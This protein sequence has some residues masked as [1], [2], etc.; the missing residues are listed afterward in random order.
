MTSDYGKGTMKFKY[1]NNLVTFVAG[2]SDQI[3]EVG[4]K[5]LERMWRKE[6]KVMP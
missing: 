1:G 5:S 6:D 2:T 4:L 3:R